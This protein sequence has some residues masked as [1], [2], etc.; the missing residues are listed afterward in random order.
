[1]TYTL[2][3]TLYMCTAN[4]RKLYWMTLNW[5]L[6]IMTLNWELSTHLQLDH[7]DLLPHLSQLGVQVALL[8][9][10]EHQLSAQ[11]LCPLSELE[12]R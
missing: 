12:L 9:L 10:Q 7:G 5:E 6:N 3:Q 11:R 1:M 8:Y 4:I 2:A